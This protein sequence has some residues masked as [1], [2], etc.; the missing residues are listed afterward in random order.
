MPDNTP[1][2]GDIIEITQNHSSGYYPSTQTLERGDRAK[3]TSVSNARRTVVAERLSDRAVVSSI[4]FN[5]FKIVIKTKEGIEREI[6]EH[7]EEIKELKEQLKFM[8]EHKKDELD[9]KEYRM[10]K[11]VIALDSNGNKVEQAK[12]IMNVLGV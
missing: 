11:L 1:K 12:N 6:R 7:Q 3:I 5:K 4:P 8:K 9:E 2:I 10:Y